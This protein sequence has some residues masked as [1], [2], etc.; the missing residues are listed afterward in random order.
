MKYPVKQFKSMEIAL[1]ELEPFIRDG[2]HLQSGR[3]FELMGGMRSR[4]ALANWLLCATVNATGGRKVTF[5]SDP[6]GGD[7][8]LIDQE[9][10]EVFPTEHVM[11]PK[12]KG[13]ENA[14]Q[15]L[16]LD[17][18]EH[19]RTKG[20]AAYASGKT[21]VVF[22]DAGAGEWFPNR[23]A[24]A[25]PDPLHF[26]AVWVVGFQRIENGSYVYGVTSLENAGG[27]APMYLVRISAGFDKWEVEPLQ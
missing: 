14:A 17:A 22:L 2:Q 20:G 7:G 16:V 4:E 26:A 11:V 10:G 21:L 19:K 25:L 18:I 12:Q 6:I 5:S 15:K 13:G 27:N 9:T 24:K 3:P 8:I 23:V 1:K